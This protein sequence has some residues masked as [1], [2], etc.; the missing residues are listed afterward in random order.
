MEEQI[1]KKA[2]TIVGLDRKVGKNQEGKEWVKYTIVD[3]ENKKYSFFTTKVDGTDT[4]A[5]AQYKQQKL[6]LNDSV[7]IAFTEEQRKF[8]DDKQKEVKYTQRNILF[9]SEPGTISDFDYKNKTDLAQDNI[10][11]I[12]TSKIPF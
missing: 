5:Y 9:F 12:D 7:G 6:T 3:D 10:E 8:I 2:I 1:Q 4:K 11:D